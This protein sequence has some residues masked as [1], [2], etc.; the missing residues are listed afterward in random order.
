M[1]DKSLLV[2]ALAIS[3]PL[4]SF[5]G[6]LVCGSSD[7]PT[8]NLRFVEDPKLLKVEFEHRD[9]VDQIVSQIGNSRGRQLER[10]KTIRIFFARDLAILG[11]LPYEFVGQGGAARVQLLDSSRSVI[12]EVQAHDLFVTSMRTPSKNA[13]LYTAG[14]IMHLNLS[15]TRLT[16]AE[17]AFAHVFDPANCKSAQD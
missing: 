15:N 7:N 14:A 2:L 16:Y 5:A 11:Q 6:D 3:F 17:I 9:A 13:S 12:A 8:H 4:P 10:A 1:C